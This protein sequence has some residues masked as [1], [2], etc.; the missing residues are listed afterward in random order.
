MP[1]GNGRLGAMVQGQLR[2]ETVVLNEDT[3]WTR[4]C[5][6]RVNPD[7]AQNLAEVRRLL[8]TGEIEKAHM[9]AEMSLIGSPKKGSAYQMLGELNLIF[10]DHCDDSMEQFREDASLTA[11]SGL[12]GKRVREYR[13]ELDLEEAVSRVQYVL[14]GAKYTREFFISQPDQVMAARLTTKKEG[15]LKMAVSLSRRFGAAVCIEGNSRIRMEGQCGTRGTRFAALLSVQASG[16]EI[17]PV[18]SY[19]YIDGAEEVILRI[20]AETDMRSQNFKEV[21]SGRIDRAEKLGYEELRKRHTE[22]YKNYY[23]RMEF[24]I[25]GEELSPEE[26]PTDERLRLVKQ[27]QKDNGL[28]SMYFNFGRYLLI[29]GSRPD[30]AAVNLQGIWCSSFV[31]DWDSKYTININTQMNY[32]P[33]EVCGLG[34]CHLPLFDLIEKARENGRKTA[35]TMYGCRGFVIHHNTDLWGDTAPYDHT[36]A[37]LWPAGGAW[38]CFHLWEHYLYSGDLEFLREKAWPIMKEAAEFF[39]D[40]LVEDENGQLLSGPSLSP[41]NRYMTKDGQTG[42][43]CMAPAMDTQIIKGLFSRCLD[44]AEELGIRD[45]FTGQVSA[46]ASKLP[47]MKIGKDGRLQEWLEDYQE[48][49]PGHRHISHLFAL[50]PDCQINRE[51]TPELYEAARKTLNRRL[52]YDGGGTGWSLAWIIAYWARFAEAEKAEETLYRLLRERTEDSL[53]DLHPPHIFQIDGNLG[54]VAGIAEMLIQCRKDTV[55][56]FPALPADWETGRI[57]GLRTPGG[58]EVSLQW[59]KDDCRIELLAHRD[60]KGTVRVGA[61]KDGR[62]DR[63][64]ANRQLNTDSS[65]YLDRHVELKGGET[66]SWEL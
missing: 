14:D 57:K 13:R 51:E 59:K 12:F 22:E 38:L 11:V 20:A 26:L 60:W 1:L 44:A 10:A 64:S 39:L 61:G 31:P 15:G 28:I 18:G 23:S 66:L 50:Y 34:D 7:A 62:L 9:L 27:G 48:T 36:R 24:A 37:G 8:M 58:L 4:D 30:S 25:S 6:D 42:S 45:E 47:P 3:V 43:L 63:N 52:Q 32:W 40:Y 35:Q 54:A 49:E 16:G 17:R 65:R 53:L 19:L 5:E 46:A 41:E 33:A 56:L 55:T 29:C 2:T 21:C